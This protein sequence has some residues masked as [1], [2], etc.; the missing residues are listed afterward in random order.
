MLEESPDVDLDKL[1]RRRGLLPDLR[2]GEPPYSVENYIRRRNEVGLLD[3]KRFAV[4]PAVEGNTTAVRVCGG[5]WR[6]NI[7]QE[8]GIYNGNIGGAC[9]RVTMWI[10][11][12]ISFECVSRE[13]THT[14]QKC[15]MS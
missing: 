14:L 15:K 12:Q 5:S 6:V 3:L 8:V 7:G 4:M 9:Q 1:Q 11:Q 13:N 10:F 2:K